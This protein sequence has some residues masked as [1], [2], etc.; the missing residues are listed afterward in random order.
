MTPGPYSSVAVYPN[1]IIGPCR[2]CIQL[3][4]NEV[5]IWVLS[6]ADSHITELVRAELGLVDDGSGRKEGAS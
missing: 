4:L 5:Y 6:P 1:R 3:F 2:C